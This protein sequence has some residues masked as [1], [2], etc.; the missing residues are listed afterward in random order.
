MQSPSHLALFFFPPVVNYKKPQNWIFIEIGG[1]ATVA[2][3]NRKWMRNEFNWAFKWLI[4]R[5]THK[6]WREG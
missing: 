1:T 4:N 2:Q 6:Y 3:D 5:S